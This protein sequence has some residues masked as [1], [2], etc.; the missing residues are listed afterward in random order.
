M[1]TRSRRAP[2]SPPDRCTC[3]TPSPAASWKTRTQV[4]V[5]S[6][7]CVASSASGL[8]QYGQPSGQRWVSS[9]SRPSGLSTIAEL[10]N[11][12]WW[13]IQCSGQARHCTSPLATCGAS[14]RG[15]RASPSSICHPR[16]RDLPAQPRTWDHPGQARYDASCSHFLEFVVGQTAQQCTDVGEVSLARRRIGLGE[17]I[18]E[19]AEGDLAGTA[20]DDLGR[21]RV[22]LEDPLGREQHPAALRLVVDEP[23]APAQARARLCGDDGGGIAQALL[24]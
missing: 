2:G 12:T 16:L 4:A 17:I 6:S 3:R 8:E 15:T 10:D 19:L 20:L 11:A 22:G 1:S 14:S 21:D 24:L 9:A 13:L 18:D 23:N 5:S 7:S